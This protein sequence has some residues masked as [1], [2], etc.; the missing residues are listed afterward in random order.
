MQPQPKTKTPRDVK[1]LKFVRTL[2]CC[3][4]GTTYN[5][6][7]HHTDTGGIALVGSDYSAV[8]LCLPCHSTLHQKHGKAGYWKEEE[9][10][11]LLERLYVAYQMVVQ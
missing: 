3:R 7:S 6:Q 1:Y 4:C 11:S 5:V 8:P 2:P 9:L 10:T